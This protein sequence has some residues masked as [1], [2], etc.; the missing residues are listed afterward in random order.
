MER[1]L[2]ILKPSAIA[3]ELV[4]AVIE[5]FQRRGLIIQGLKMIQLDDAILK[6]HYAH[7][8]DKPFFPSI[9]RSMKATPVIVM[10]LAGLDAVNVVRA[11]TGA[12]NGRN[13]TP[14][15]IRG[16]FCVSN[17]QNIVHASDSVENANIELKRFFSDNELF[18][19][20]TANFRNIYADDEV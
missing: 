10:A 14:G 4:G 17:Q 7:L 8:V 18:D 3:R 20:Q 6:E 12:T 9:A 2:V 16:D 19:Y 1:T 13:A 5:R 11:M 15:T